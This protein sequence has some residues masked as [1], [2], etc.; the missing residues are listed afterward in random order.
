ME[1]SL[2][3]AARDSLKYKVKWVMISA[4]TEW[5]YFGA[6]VEANRSFVVKSINEFF[7]DFVLNI[8]LNRRESAQV[9]KSEIMEAIDKYLGVSDFFIWDTR[10]R[11][12]IE[13]SQIGVMRCGHI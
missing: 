4:D 11:R 1:P 3:Y 10:F 6:G 7:P 8:A 5:T 9:N 12:V 2:I 13:F